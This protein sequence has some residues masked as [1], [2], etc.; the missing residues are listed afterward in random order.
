MKY[1]AKLEEDDRQEV[2]RSRQ[3]AACLRPLR[4]P[5]LHARH[6]GHHPEPGPQRQVAESL[7]QSKT[8][9]PRF[10]YDSYR[11]FIQMFSDVV[12]E[13]SAKNI[14]SSSST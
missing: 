6:D 9:N 13:L 4:R 12:M 8:N 2:R 10:A 7:V 5:R 1:V 11:R 3:S 14:L